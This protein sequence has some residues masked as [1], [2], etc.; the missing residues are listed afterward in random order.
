MSTADLSFLHLIA[1]A[2]LLVQL[3]IVVLLLMSFVSWWFIFH[4]WFVIRAAKK[5]T[6]DFEERFHTEQGAGEMSAGK[7]RR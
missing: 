2:S 7:R 5:R 1:N 3:V 6:A 4:K